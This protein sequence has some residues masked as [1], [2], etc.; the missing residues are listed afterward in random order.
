MAPGKPMRNGFVLSFSGCLG[1]ELLND[2]LFRSLARARDLLG[3]GSA[4]TTS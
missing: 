4:T 1:G 3:H 2:T